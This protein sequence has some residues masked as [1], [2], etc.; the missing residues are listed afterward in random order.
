MNK[1]QNF[2]A[3]AENYL[4][5]DFIMSL[6]LAAVTAELSFLKLKYSN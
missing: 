5:W 3:T 6:Q 4:L 1:K 2:A